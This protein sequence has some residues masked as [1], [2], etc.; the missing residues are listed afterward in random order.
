M[1]KGLSSHQVCGIVLII[2]MIACFSYQF[3]IKDTAS[4]RSSGMAKYSFLVRIE[5]TP[6]GWIDIKVKKYYYHI[7]TKIVYFIENGAFIKLE[8][9]T[10]DKFR[11]NEKTNEFIG[12]RK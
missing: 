10:Y 6:K 8:S 2:F 9:E 12:V 11:Y 1:N 5:E 7:D 3:G 4:T